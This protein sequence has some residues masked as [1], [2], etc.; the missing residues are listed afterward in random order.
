[1]RAYLQISRDDPLLSLCIMCYK[2]CEIWKCF[3][4][5]CQNNHKL[6]R[7]QEQHL[8]MLQDGQQMIRPP[9][10]IKTEPPDYYMVESLEEI[11][12]G[13]AYTLDDEVAGAHLIAGGGVPHYEVDEEGSCDPLGQNGTKRKRKRRKRKKIEV[14]VQVVQKEADT[15]LPVSRNRSQHSGERKEVLNMI[16]GNEISNASRSLYMKTYKDFL[17]WKE[18]NAVDEIDEDVLLAYFKR[19]TPVYSATTLTNKLSHISNTMSSFH[20]V[21][22]DQFHR[23]RQYVRDVRAGVLTGVGDFANGSV[24]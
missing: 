11:A 19:I 14:D 22:V 23:L 10:E 5:R 8:Q 17:Q 18:E 16:T 13:A 7:S 2:Q 1:M 12:V 3:K 9:A 24:S 21:N 4:R 20:S 15:S 6:I